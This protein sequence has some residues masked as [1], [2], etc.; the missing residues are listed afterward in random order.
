MRRELSASAKI[1]CKSKMVAQINGDK[2][3]FL[4]VNTL[5]MLQ[6][7]FTLPL[8]LIMMVFFTPGVIELTAM[9]LLTRTNSMPK[10]VKVQTTQTLRQTR[11]LGSLLDNTKSLI[12]L[13]DTSS[14]SSK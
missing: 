5:P 9:I 12:W 11:L 10:K 7:S 3:N 8:V 1:P 4:K 2:S 6:A 14:V 13:Q